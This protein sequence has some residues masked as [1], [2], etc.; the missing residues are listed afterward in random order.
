MCLSP[1]KPPYYLGMSKIT[2]YLSLKSKREVIF[3]D[4][5]DNISEGGGGTQFYGYSEARLIFN[6][7]MRVLD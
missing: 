7:V 3:S 2:S 4:L 5:E 1:L 6:S